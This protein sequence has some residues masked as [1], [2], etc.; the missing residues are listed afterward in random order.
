MQHAPPPTKP[1]PVVVPD[2]NVLISSLIGRRNEPSPPARILS[3]WKK[4]EIIIVLSE[5][6]MDKINDVLHRPVLFPFLSARFSSGGVEKQIEDF[7]HAL[8][9]RARITLG[10]LDIKVVEADPED[11]TILIA[12]VEGKADCIISGD[13]HLK[14]LGSYKSIPILS[15]TEFVEQYNIGP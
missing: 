14:N 1:R 8:R 5:P 6:I 9:R 11:D 12:A 13:R 4:G 15:P 2:V 3:A 10:V 7:L